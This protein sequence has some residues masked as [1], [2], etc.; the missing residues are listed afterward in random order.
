[1]NVNDFPLWTAII[2]PLFENGE[3]DFDSLGNLITEQTKAHNGILVLGSTG[4]ALNLSLA[5]KKE[6]LEFSLKQKTTV[7]IMAGVGGTN[8]NETKKWVEYLETK[9]LDA[10]LMVTPIYAKPG[11]FGQYHWFKTLLDISSRPVML[12]NIPSRSGISLCL[13]TVKKL[14]G[15]KNFWAIKEASGSSSDFQKYKE[16]APDVAIFSGDDAK[17]PEFS[18]LG[19]RGLVSVASNVWPT[20]TALYVKQSLEN[21]LKNSSCAL[22]EESSNALFVTSNPVPVKTLLSKLKK[23]TSPITRPPLSEKDLKDISLLINADENIKNWYRS[24]K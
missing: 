10:Y 20:E 19:A 11:H 1:M 16:A 4:E 21:S 6:I 23:I 24:E 13:E 18:K 22:W 3:I 9:Q 7:P 2:T 14:D 15:H 8:L 17:M 12:Y 5:E